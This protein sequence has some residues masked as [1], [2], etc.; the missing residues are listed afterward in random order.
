MRKSSFE[1]L[2]HTLGIERDIPFSAD[3]SINLPDRGIDMHQ[4]TGSIKEYDFDR[5]HG[6]RM[7]LAER[8]SL[9]SFHC[10]LKRDLLR[11]FMVDQ[12]P[13]TQTGYRA[14]QEELKRL[15]NEERPK[16][17]TEVEK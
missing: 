10:Q 8:Y 14:L 6:D 9:K 1:R 17:I 13:M 2:F 7:K 4:G 11:N 16:I 15:M 12:I 5:R 3:P